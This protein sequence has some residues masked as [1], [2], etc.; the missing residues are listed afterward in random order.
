MEEKCGNMQ[1]SDKKVI[2]LFKIVCYN[3]TKNWEKEAATQLN[4]TLE[5]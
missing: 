4:I 5:G 1:F 2:D 3:T